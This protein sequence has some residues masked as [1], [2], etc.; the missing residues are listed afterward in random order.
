[1]DIEYMAAYVPDVVELMAVAWPTAI[2]EVSRQ[3]A[4]LQGS[5]EQQP[6]KCGES[7]TY[8]CWGAIQVLSRGPLR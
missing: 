6:R 4:A 1:M 7:Q 3:P 2:V 5:L 8:H